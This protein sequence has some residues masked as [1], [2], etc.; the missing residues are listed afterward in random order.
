MS[1][2]LTEI[3]AKILDAVT[4]VS[5]GATYQNNTN[6]PKQY[7]ASV[8][9]TGAVSA[10]VKLWGANL[11]P[12]SDT[13]KA[14]LLATFTLSGTTAASD[15]FHSFAGWTFVFGEVTAISGTS[16]AVTLAQRS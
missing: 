12:A 15:G 6:A 3:V 4:T 13:T 8:A 10:T 2:R 5:V 14:A 16:A 1:T 11:D 9:G 7:Q